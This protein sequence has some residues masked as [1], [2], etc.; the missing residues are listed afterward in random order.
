MPTPETH[1]T[2][3]PNDGSYAPCILTEGPWVPIA[4]LEQRLR[5]L[6]VLAHYNDM[7]GAHTLAEYRR[8][9][10]ALISGLIS[11]VPA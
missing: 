8:N 3:G 11:G 6:R 7:M 2:P 10:I 1:L 4:K 9:E 5:E